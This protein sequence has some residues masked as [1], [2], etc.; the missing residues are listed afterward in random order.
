LGGGVSFYEGVLHWRAPSP[1]TDPHWNYIV[2]GAAALFEGASFVIALRQFRRET[3]GQRFWQALHGSKDPTTFTVL[4]EDGAA[5]AGL[6]IA[7]VGVYTSHRFEIPRLDG[8]ASMLIGLLLAS[9][10]AL[11]IYESRSLLIGE[12]IRPETARQVRA[13]AAAHPEIV[14][15]GWPLSMYV[16]R[17]AVLLTL[18]VE[19][20]DGTPA[21]RVAAVVAEIEREVGE[22]FPVVRHFY[23]EAATLGRPDTLHA[24]R[25]RLP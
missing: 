2:L 13:M 1:L 25:G 5:L 12:G 16:G 6:L 19:F 15:V 23:V 7:A 24:S 10:A 9:V 18:E 11:L 21:E 17:D 4:A 14:R 20:M 3:R 8:V 22:R